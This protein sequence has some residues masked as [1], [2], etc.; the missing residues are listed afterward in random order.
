MPPCCRSSGC[1]AARRTA[2]ST[3]RSDRS[4]REGSQSAARG[5]VRRAGVTRGR[6][7]TPPWLARLGRGRRM[8]SRTPRHRGDAAPE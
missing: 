3:R 6:A 8:G 5:P 4:R 2:A 7:C 1:G